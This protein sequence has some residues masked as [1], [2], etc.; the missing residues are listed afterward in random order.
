VPYFHVVFTLTHQL[1]PL[2]QR[3]PRQFYDLLFRASAQTMLE[4]A[5]DPSTWEPR[6]A[7]SAFYIPGDRTCDCILISTASFRRRFRP[8]L[9]SL[10]SS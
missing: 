1:N 2:S 9:F 5:T 6:S 8:K 7:S 3:Y 4:V 10:G